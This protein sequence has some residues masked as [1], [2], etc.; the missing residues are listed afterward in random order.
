MR[1]S[2]FYFSFLIP[3]SDLFYPLFSCASFLVGNPEK[4][5]LLRGGSPLRHRRRR[6][7]DFVGDCLDSA[8]LLMGLPGGVG[9]RP[10]RLP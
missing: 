3:W 10:N 6:L 5:V 1:S 9:T 7:V 8:V 4:K 2:F